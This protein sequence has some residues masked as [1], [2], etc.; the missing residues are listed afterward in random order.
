M[1]HCNSIC[2]L[3]YIIHDFQKRT[4]TIWPGIVLEFIDK[5]QFFEFVVTYLQIILIDDFR[6]GHPNNRNHRNVIPNKL[7][8]ERVTHNEWCGLWYPGL[9]PYLMR[10]DTIVLCYL[11]YNDHWSHNALHSC[12]SK[13]FYFLNS[14]LTYL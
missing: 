6:S 1:Q 11:N 4:I 12:I 9:S 14:N 10:K 5:L 7:S 2:I 3:N 13:F 8:S